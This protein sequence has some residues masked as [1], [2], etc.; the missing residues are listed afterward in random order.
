MT[1]TERIGILVGGRFIADHQPPL[2]VY[3]AA[4]K[5]NKNA[6]YSSP[7]FYPQCQKCSSRQRLYLGAVS[8]GRTE[9]FSPVVTHASALRLH[10]LWLPW[11]IQRLFAASDTMSCVSVDIS[12]AASICHT[13][14]SILQGSFGPNALH[15]M[16]S[17][18]TGQVLITSDGSTI[19]KSLHLSHPVGNLIM[20]AVQSHH[21]ITGDGT[22]TFLLMLR[23]ALQTIHNISA[24]TLQVVLSATLGCLKLEC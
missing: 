24:K 12:T 7:A 5:R 17:T 8:R 16:I 23:E 6:K 20:D 1:L 11:D 18:A 19:I 2:A 22:K 15:N 3:E 14:C 13:V 4:L 10:H 9:P 21:A